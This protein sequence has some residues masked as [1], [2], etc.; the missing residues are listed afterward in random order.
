VC[1]CNIPDHYGWDKINFESIGDFRPLGIT[2][3]SNALLVFG[4]DEESMDCGLLGIQDCR[5]FKIF[6]SLDH[7]KTWHYLPNEYLSIE[8]A[9]T[10]GDKLLPEKIEKLSKKY[11]KILYYGKK[12]YDIVAYTEI[13]KPGE[14]WVD[15]N[16]FYMYQ[17]LTLYSSSDQ[18]VTWEELTI[19]KNLP[20]PI[21]N[22][23]L[24]EFIDNHLLLHDPFTKF[25]YI[26]KRIGNHFAFVGNDNFFILNYSNG[27]KELKFE[28]QNSL[29]TNYFMYTNSKT[30]EIEIRPSKEIEREDQTHLISDFYINKKGVVFTN[31]AQKLNPTTFGNFFALSSN[32]KGKIFSANNYPTNMGT[33]DITGF[34]AVGFINELPLIIYS[35]ERVNLSTP[36]NNN[37]WVRF[38]ALAWDIT[39]KEAW[40]ITVPDYKTE[41]IIRFI[42]GFKV[43]GKYLYYYMNN[44][45]FR[46]PIEQ[47][48]I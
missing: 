40:Y 22:N 32:D 45:L 4:Y 21:D 6:R 2:G 25:K 24:I 5:L 27:R 46:Y 15:G 47:I 23:T 19:E 14:Y 1:S 12:A 42:S 41:S 44:G 31:I 13:F 34:K 9:I 35:I 33:K 17:D 11:G 38:Y 37:T 3:N 7:G 48:R 26:F 30:Q 16:F 8:H 10:K 20:L 18:G 29:C 39:K 28:G 36:I 43:H